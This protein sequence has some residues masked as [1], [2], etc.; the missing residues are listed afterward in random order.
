MSENPEKYVDDDPNHPLIGTKMVGNIVTKVIETI[1]PYSDRF[2]KIKRAITLDNG[3]LL[4]QDEFV[5]KEDEEERIERLKREKAKEE[6]AKAQ[7]AS[8]A[9]QAK[10]EAAAE[11]LRK[12]KKLEEEKAAAKTVNK[13]REVEHQQEVVEQKRL[14]DAGGTSPRKLLGSTSKL[15]LDEGIRNELSL[16]ENDVPASPKKPNSATRLMETKSK[17]PRAGG[18]ATTKPKIKNRLS[19][20]LP[21]SP[22]GTNRRFK[23]TTSGSDTQ[24][25]N[26]GRASNSSLPFMDGSDHLGGS[27][28]SLD[29]GDTGDVLYRKARDSLVSP[30]PEPK[31]S[32]SAGDG[33]RRGRSGNGS[34]T[35]RMQRPSAVGGA[36]PFGDN[37]E[38]SEISIEDILLAQEER[39]KLLEEKDKLQQSWKEFEDEKAENQRKWERE[40]ARLEEEQRK[41][42]HRERAKLEEER[43]RLEEERKR[44]EEE[45]M[46]YEE[47]RKKLE[48]LEKQRQLSMEEKQRKLELEE[49]ARLEEE[50]VRQEQAKLRRDLEEEQAKRQQS[51]EK[52][53]S[54]LDQEKARLEAERKKMEKERQQFEEEKQRLLEEERRKIEEEARAQLEEEKRKLV[55]QQQH[56]E[57]LVPIKGGDGESG[58]RKSRKSG[59]KSS[60]KSKSKDKKGGSGGVDD[61]KSKSSKKSDKKKSKKGDSSKKS[62]KKKSSD[63]GNGDGDRLE[64]IK[65]PKSS[66]SKKKATKPTSDEGAKKKTQTFDKIMNVL[67]TRE[68]KSYA[69]PLET[70]RRGAD[71]PKPVLTKEDWAKRWGE[72]GNSD[73]D[74][75][76]E[77]PRAK[78]QN[79]FG[80]TLP[81]NP[82][83]VAPVFKKSEAEKKMIA[84]SFE[85]DFVFNDLAPEAVG[86][87]VDAFERIE[88]EQ[89]ATIAN[90]GEPDSYYSIVQAGEVSFHADGQKIGSAGPGETFGELALLYSRP[91]GVDVR[92]GDHQTVLFQINQSNFRQVMREQMH[93]S[94]EEKTKL[95]R[96]VPMFKDV[97]ESDLKQLSAAMVPINFKKGENLS[98]TFRDA[99]FCLV[100]QGSVVATDATIGPGQSYGGNSMKKHKEANKFEVAAESDGVVFTIDRESFDKVFGDFDRLSNKFRDKETLVRVVDL[101]RTN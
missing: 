65:S 2:Y 90:Q 97:D 95:L 27:T 92:V 62:S 73:R 38:M 45:R 101:C 5:K 21:T 17:S 24:S 7:A 82:D 88:Y 29:L 11:K 39:K 16:D 34:M 50:R 72:K 98:N 23:S 43:R 18:G 53:R 47:E 36:V 8:A 9:K 10:E 93:R 20:H 79:V 57:T 99:P 86:T 26:S 13:I 1:V 61:A 75:P 64:P 4:N 84:K 70:V 100:Q 25:L 67:G 35:R 66:K 56:N 28:T 49:K 81:D 46:R 30:A 55:E 14:E 12:K 68:A 96:S 83:F 3:M 69:T 78:L 87:L 54:S 71:M 6:R 76:V 85:K 19:L 91:R 15:S 63:Q 41:M 59:S 94:E 60:G 22:R 37:D 31:R 44:R 48:D 89:G 40:R 74:L 42:L 51:V 80:E 52:A 77:A 32:V 58:K 33:R